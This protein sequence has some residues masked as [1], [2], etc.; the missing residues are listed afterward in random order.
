MSNESRSRAGLDALAAAVGAA[1]EPRP[2]LLA[3]YAEDPD[4]LAPEERFQFHTWMLTA[5][6]SGD[7]ALK[8]FRSGATDER[9]WEV[10]ARHLTNLL[11][12]PGVRAWASQIDTPFSEE[13]KSFVKDA[14]TR[15]ET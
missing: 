10:Q 12:A 11:G 2:E 7:T 14:L 15:L 3:R 9:E 4:S 8:L 5:F 13:F 6:L 1:D